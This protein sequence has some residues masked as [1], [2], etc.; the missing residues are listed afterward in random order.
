MQFQFNA[1]EWQRLTPE[2][3]ARRCR[4]LAAEA[5]TLAG[6]ATAHLKTLY[7]ELALQWK[8]LAEELER[9]VALYTAPA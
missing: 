3:R 4:I 8:M 1:G 9:Q 7:L 5:E 2:G 6:G